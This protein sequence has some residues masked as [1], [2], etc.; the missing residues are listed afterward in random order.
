M[1][2]IKM[3]WL[4]LLSEKGEDEGEAQ[5]G[6]S[7]EGSDQGAQQDEG[8]QGQG[9][10]NASPDQQGQQGE[11]AGQAEPSA[12]ETPDAATLQAERDELARKHETLVGQSQATERN[13]A[14][15]RKALSD[16]GLK[17]AQDGDGNVV[18][19]PISKS[20]KDSRFTDEHR[21]KFFS[22]FPSAEDGEGFLNLMN[23]L[24][25]DFVGSK[26]T[27][28]DK[29]L[30]Q[31]QQFQLQQAEANERMINLF[32]SL[33]PKA[34]SFNRSFYDKATEIWEARYKKLP[35]GELL[36][37]NEASLEMGIAPSSVAQA[38][39]E[40][41]QKGKEQ[42]KIVGSGQQGSHAQA[43]GGFRKLS[44]EEYQKLSEDEREKYD[45][46]EVESRKG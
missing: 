25:E 30:S 8:Q 18:V 32:P 19:V 42:R 15:T 44:Y 11:P 16:M 17:W 33:D 37:A 2:F 10:P 3:I 21:S 22:Y 12:E 38:K 5:Q 6:G 9:D 39:K 23:L 1:S 24:L 36:A 41:F 35:N 31:R 13:L 7:A 34:K 14:A 43:S 46:K 28:Y 45:L 26:L 29:T 40:G 20:G 4:Y 27:N